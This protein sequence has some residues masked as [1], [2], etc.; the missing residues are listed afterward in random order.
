VNYSLRY[1]QAQAYSIFINFL[2]AL[3]EPEKFENLVLVCVGDAD[4]RVS[5][6]YPQ[7]LVTR[8]QLSRSFYNNL[9]V[10]REFQ[11]VGLQ[12]QK[13]LL[14]P[15]LVGLNNWRTPTFLSIGKAW[16]LRTKVNSNF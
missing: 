10:L 9:S 8:S 7:I 2:G 13:Y 15:L 1:D 16:V 6:C 11:G 5:H 12:V 4:T 14:Q 3:N